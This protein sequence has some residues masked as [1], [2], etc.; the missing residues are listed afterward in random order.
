MC[1]SRPVVAALV[2]PIAAL[3]LVL[4]A[5]TL[6]KSSIHRFTHAWWLAGLFAVI[7]AVAAL[8]ISPRQR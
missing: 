1:R 3:V 4:G 6:S 2:A 7:A 8:G 5:S